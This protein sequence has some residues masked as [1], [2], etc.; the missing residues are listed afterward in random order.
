MCE[1]FNCDFAALVYTNPLYYALAVF[2]K[3][4]AWIKVAYINNYIPIRNSVM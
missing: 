1:E 2:L 4:W 3:K